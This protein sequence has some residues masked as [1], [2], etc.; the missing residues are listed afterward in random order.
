MQDINQ[1]IIL[2]SFCPEQYFSFPGKYIFAAVGATVVYSY[3]FE[4]T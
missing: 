2:Y 1:Y 4:A 3:P